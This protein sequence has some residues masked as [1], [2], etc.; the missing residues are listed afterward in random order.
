MFETPMSRFAGPIAV[1]AGVSVLATRLVI[2][3][4][5]PAERGDPL[6]AAV[7]SPVNTVNSIASIA[8]FG[9]LAI[10][11]AAIYDR[12]AR[13]AG[14]F[15]LIAFGAAMIGTVFMAGDWWYEA[16]A[17]PWMADVAPVVFDT[18]AGGPLLAG[19]LLS[20][21]LFALGWAMFGIASLRAGV[22]PRSISATILVAGIGAGIP[23][24][25]AY[26]YASLVFGLAIAWLGV[27]LRRANDARTPAVGAAVVAKG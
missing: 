17:V 26:L 24:A 6:K 22:F 13:A 23:I 18:G 11:L 9:L 5:I 7:L 25:G 1:V 10:A 16:F 19:G 2:M 15:G 4:T 20:F 8:A 14:S 27:W 12:Q 3:L 21:A